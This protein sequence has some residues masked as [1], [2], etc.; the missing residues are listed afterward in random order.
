MPIPREPEIAGALTPYGQSLLN[1]IY[2]AV[3]DGVCPNCGQNI[4]H[5]PCGV[6]S[7]PENHYICLFCTLIVTEKEMSQMRQVIPH[8]GREAVAFFEHWRK[9]IPKT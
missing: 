7:V 6:P 8:W 9:T 1:K 5:Y 4:T 3:H 2:R